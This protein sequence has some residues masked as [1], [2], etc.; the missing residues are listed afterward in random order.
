[1][2]VDREF[3]IY[4]WTHGILEIVLE[5]D[6]GAK[7][8]P[9]GG[10]GR[11]HGSPKEAFGWLGA[12][13]GGGSNSGLHFPRTCCKNMIS[14]SVWEPA[15]YTEPDEVDFCKMRHSGKFRPKVRRA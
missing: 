9:L 5:G 13:L 4:F 1:M 12:P 8:K 11:C 14:Y 7:W 15:R 2:A 3:D 6:L 10:L